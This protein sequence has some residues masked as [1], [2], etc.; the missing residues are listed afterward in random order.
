M[1]LLDLILKSLYFF[2]PVYF[3]NMTPVFLA[4][5]KYL[6]NLNAPMDFGAK[7]GKERLFGS[8]KTWRGFIGSIIAAIVFVFIQKALFKYDFFNSI[9]ILNYNEANLFLLGFLFGFGAMFG[10]LVKSFFKRRLG[11]KPGSSW[12]IFDQLDYVIGALLFVSIIHR[13]SLDVILTLV[14]VTPFLNLLANFL[15]YLL[16]L[17]K[18]WW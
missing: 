13:V 6:K 14:I 1:A 17:K 11:K 9:S 4:K 3:A 7:F 16:K 15:G 5:I 18:V 10:D 2:V 12:P 8:N